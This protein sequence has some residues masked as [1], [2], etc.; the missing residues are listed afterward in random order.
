MMMRTYVT[1]IAWALSLAAP[2]AATTA[3]YLEASADVTLN[4]SGVTVDDGDLAIDDLVDPIA[5]LSFPGIVSPADLDAHAIDVDGNDLISLDVTVVVGQVG[6]GTLTA[7]PADAIRRIGVQYELA[8]DASAAGVPPGANLDALFAFEDDLFLSFDVSLALGGGVVAHDE[9]VLRWDGSQLSL[10]RDTSATGIDPAAD[11]DALHFVTG[12]GALVASF[13]TSGAVDGFNYDDDDLL[14]FDP[15]TLSWSLSFEGSA[16]DA[17]WQAGDLDAA[18]PGFDLDEDGVMDR[19]DLCP[20]FADPGQLDTDGNGIG[21]E[22]ECGDQNGDGTVNVEDIL[23]INEVIFELQPEQP[24]CD[25]NDDGL[26]N[27][28]DILGANAKIF[29]ASAHCSRYPTPVFP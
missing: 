21:D 18:T 1:A 14:A 28:A 17:A 22:C 16:R 23:A 3:V 25:T 12:T 19:E 7:R 13:D 10:Y 27:V 20:R 29:G 4:L 2:A 11:L 8:F 15:G 26:C 5:R 9:D 24:L 6:G